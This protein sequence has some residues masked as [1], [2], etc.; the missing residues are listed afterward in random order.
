MVRSLGRVNAWL[1]TSLKMFCLRKSE[2]LVED[3]A[4][5]LFSQN[6]G[7]LFVRLMGGKK[8]QANVEHII[9]FSTSEKIV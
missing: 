8:D 7:V 5:W 2:E 6:D 9:V 3:I 4:K 1:E